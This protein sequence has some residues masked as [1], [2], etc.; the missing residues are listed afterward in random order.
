M[1]TDPLSF[2]LQGKHAVITGAGSGI[3]QACAELFAAAGAHV[4]LI[5]RD[6]N[7]LKEVYRGLNH[8]DRQ[9][10]IAE[11]DIRNLSE[12]ELAFGHLTATWPGIDIVVINAGIN[13]VWAPLPQLSAQEWEETLHI[14]LTGTFFTLKAALPRLASSGASIVIV[15]SI[16]GSRIFRSAGATAYACSKAGQVALAKMAALELAAKGIRVNVICPGSVETSIEES[17]TQR[18]TAHLLPPTIYPEGHIPLT[19]NQPGTPQQMALAVTFLASPLSSHI[20]GTELFID[21]A[22]SLL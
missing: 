16:N 19:Q 4:G 17:M 5:D 9:H 14:N 15:S 10:G 1:P 12:L 3:G 13:G 22:E 20:T 21:G 11:A 6:C 8:L 18:R 2:R 7:R